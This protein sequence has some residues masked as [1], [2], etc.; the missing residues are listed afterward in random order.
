[1]LCVLMLISQHRLAALCITHTP[2]LARA[3]LALLLLLLLLFLCVLLR[4][5]LSLLLL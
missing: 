3:L 4:L 1:M 2:T 5:L